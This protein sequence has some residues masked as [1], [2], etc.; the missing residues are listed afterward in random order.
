MNHIATYNSEVNADEV[1][2]LCDRVVR[3]EVA[4]WENT[5]TCPICVERFERMNKLL[6]SLSTLT[7]EQQANSLKKITSLLPKPN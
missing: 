1:V 6:H 2:T 3:R 4:D 5:I 7:P